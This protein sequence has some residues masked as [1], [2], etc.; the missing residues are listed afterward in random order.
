MPQ[1]RAIVPDSGAIRAG[2]NSTG[3]TIAKYRLV[4]KATVTTGVQ[5]GVDT[6]TPAVDGTVIIYGAT[7][8]AIVDGATG[9]VQVQGRALVEAAGAINIG[10]KI[11]G[12][13]GG[14]AAVSGGG[15]NIIGQAASPALVD[16]DIFECD[17]LRTIG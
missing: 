5:A 12:T 3:S 10:D 7:M 8:A 9:D 14:K 1:P 2:L 11:I 16:G 15:V 13:T 17:I 6:V 4:K